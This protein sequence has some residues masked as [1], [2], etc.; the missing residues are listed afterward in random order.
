MWHH[1]G[2]RARTR[3][4]NSLENF[5]F[6]VDRVMGDDSTLLCIAAKSGHEDAIRWLI[7]AGSVI[8]PVNRSRT[9]LG[10]AIQFNRE[11]IVRCLTEEL[12]ADVN[13]ATEDFAHLHTWLR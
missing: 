5:G 3:H 6:N 12:D 7:K 9:P 8:I 1:V 13:L 4:C 10:V 2:H 11:R